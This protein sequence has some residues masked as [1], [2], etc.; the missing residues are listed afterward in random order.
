MSNTRSTF[1]LQAAIARQSARDRVPGKQFRQQDVRCLDK[2]RAVRRPRT[3]MEMVGTEWL[4]S[5]SVPQ[6]SA[7]RPR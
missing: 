2:A 4:C 3:A 7:E 6:L 5:R 1:C